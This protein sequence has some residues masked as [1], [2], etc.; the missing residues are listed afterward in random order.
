MMEAG[1][2]VV[3]VAEGRVWVR[4]QQQLGGCGRCDEPGGC[5]ATR[6]S[7]IFKPSGGEVCL[8]DSMGFQVGERVRI[9]VPE[10]APLRAALLSYGLPLGLVL[11][12]GAAFGALA[13]FV[14]G[15]ANVLAGVVLGLLLGVVLGRRIMAGPRW[16]RALGLSL[17]RAD[18]AVPACGVGP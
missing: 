7:D 6:L 10:G 16:R 1:A 12:L 13:P 11:S 2:T 5:Q 9:A 17:R 8:P 15:D 4:L 18:P 3:R 14:S